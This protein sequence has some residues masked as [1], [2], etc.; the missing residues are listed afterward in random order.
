MTTPASGPVPPGWYPD[1]AE[2]PQWRVWTGHAWSELTRPYSI[3]PDEASDARPLVGDLGLV[4]ALHRLVAYGVVAVFAGLGLLVG[5]AAHWPG[6]T[7]PM[8]ATLAA[9]LLDVALAMLTVGTVAYS[10][11]G[12]ELLGRWTVP[13]VVP[14]LNVV[15][16]TSLIDRRLNARAPVRRLVLDVAV[17]VLF[18]LQ[19]HQHP[20]LAVLPALV[21]IDLAG[22]AQR[23]GLEI[24]TRASPTAVGP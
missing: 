7:R 8:N 24:V 21:A 10:V 4:T 13:I 20:Y 9:T 15:V 14:G 16:V 1:P 19:S 18:V 2:A 17:L 3:E 6:T 12:R 11:V 23:L 5:V 22:A